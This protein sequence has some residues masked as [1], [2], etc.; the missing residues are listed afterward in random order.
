MALTASGCSSLHFSEYE[1][2]KK[3]TIFDFIADLG[4]LFGLC[5]GFSIISCFEIIFWTS[6]AVWNNIAK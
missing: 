4:G 3:M 2:S 1:K 6:I 5:L